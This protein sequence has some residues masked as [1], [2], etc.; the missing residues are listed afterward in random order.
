MDSLGLAIGVCFHDIALAKSPHLLNKAG[1]LDERELTEIKKHPSDGF[2]IVSAFTKN[3]VAHEAVLHHHE[4]VDGSGYP[5]ALT[6]DEISP[7]GKILAIADSFHAMTERR[8]HKK[9]SKNV[10]RAAAEINALSGKMYDE[11]LVK[12]FN[13]VLRKHWLPEHAGD[14][15][16]QGESGE[17]PTFMQDILCLKSFNRS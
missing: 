17:A 10:L 5:Y 2:T 7:A 4:R 16:P 8:P 15:A 3:E 9:F 1:R 11:S 13:H 6:S 12:V 14:E